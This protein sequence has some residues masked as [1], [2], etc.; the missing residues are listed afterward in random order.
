M[1]IDTE[2]LLSERA[3]G[4]ETVIPTWGPG[5][6]REDLRA[7]RLSR[8]LRA[9]ASGRTAFRSALRRVIHCVRQSPCG[10]LLFFPHS[11]QP[12]GVRTRLALLVLVLASF[13]LTAGVAHAK[14]EVILLRTAG[15]PVLDDAAQRVGGGWRQDLRQAAQS[16][17]TGPTRG[18]VTELLVY[19]DDMTNTSRVHAS[20]HAASGEVP[21]T[22]L[23]AFDPP[24]IML[25]KGMFARPFIRYT[26]PVTFPKLDR[27]TQYFIVFRE[28]AES[29]YDF[30]SLTS[31]TRDDEDAAGAEGWTLANNALGRTIADWNP[32]GGDTIWL[33][34]KG[35]LI[36]LGDADLTALTLQGSDGNV[37]QYNP[38]FD[39]DTRHYSVTVPPEVKNITV[40]PTTSDDDARV[41]YRD[42]R[43][44]PIPDLDPA[45]AGLQT[46]LEVGQNTVR[47]RVVA[48]EGKV[49]VYELTVTRQ[50]L[51]MKD[52][53]L[54]DP[55]DAAILFV[56][57]FTPSQA[58]YKAYVPN[59]T[60]TVTLEPTLNT[61]STKGVSLKFRDPDDVIPD[62]DEATDGHQIPL[63]LG[64]NGI[65]MTATARGQ[66]RDYY[67]T[68][69]RGESADPLTGQLS[70]DKARDDLSGYPAWHFDLLLSEPVRIS[71]TELRQHTFEITNGRIVKAQAAGD[72]P[73]YAA[74][75]RLTLEPITPLE[76]ST[77][78]L[79]SGLECGT[80]GALCVPAADHGGTGDK[81]LGGSP[82]EL[83]LPEWGYSGPTGKGL[84]IRVDDTSQPENRG[85]LGV[86]LLF[87]DSDDKAAASP[88]PVRLRMR[89]VAETGPDKATAGVDYSPADHEIIVPHGMEEYPVNIATLLPDS[90]DDA[91]EKVK[92]RLSDAWSLDPFGMRLYQFKFERRN[93]DADV[94]KT[95]YTV[96]TVITIDAPVEQS[97]TMGTITLSDPTDISPGI[98]EF[99]STRS[100]QNMQKE[101]RVCYD[102]E[103]LDTGTATPGE[104][105]HPQSMRVYMQ[106]DERSRSH[107]VHA[108]R[109][110]VDDEGETVDVQIS[111]ARLCNEPAMG[112]ETLNGTQTWTL[113]EPSAPTGRFRGPPSHDGQT[114]FSMQLML[115]DPVSRTRSEM[116]DQTIKTKGGQ[117]TVDRVDGQ[118][119]RWDISVVPDG[120]E[121]VVLTIGGTGSC[122]DPAT[123]CTEDGEPFPD[124]VTTTVPGPGGPPPLTASFEEVPVTHDG[125]TSFTLR[126]SLSAPVANSVDDLRDHALTVTGGS[127]ETVAAIDGRRDL[128]ELT[129]AP[130]GLGNV[131]VT[132]EAGGDCSDLGTLCTAR[133]AVLS[134]TIRA[135][136]EGP[137]PGP[138]LSV[139]FED[140]PEEHDGNKPFTVNVEFSEP[141]AGI[142]NKLLREI[143]QVDG[144]T[145]VQV[146]R[147]TDNNAHRRV[148]I[149]PDG[150][151]L[152]TLSFPATVDCADPHALCTDAGGKLES[153]VTLA[154][155]G[156]ESATPP[157][158][159][160]ALFSNAPDE[161][162]GTAAF[163]V[164]IEFSEAPVGMNNQTLMEVL[165]VDGGTPLQ[166]QGVNNDPSHYR[167]EIEPDG[168]GTVTVSFA[169]TSNCSDPHALCTDSGGRLESGLSL[170]I[171]GPPP[172]ASGP[173]LTASFVNV[174]QE[175]D[176]EKSFRLEIVFSEV[177]VG[178]TN[179]S[180][181]KIL[182]IN[183]GT[184]GGMTKVDDNA[185]HRRLRIDPIRDRY[186]RIT[187]SLPPTTDCRAEGALCSAAGGK[188][189]QG[190]ETIIPGPVGIRVADAR[191]EEGPDATL[192]FVVSLN[193]SPPY[194]VSVDYAT[195]NGT[196]TAGVDY[197]ATSGTLTFASG[198]TSKTVSVPVHD[199]AHD[200]DDET[201]LFRLSN[202]V[203]GRI[204]DGGVAI[205]TIDNSDHMP[206][207]WLGRLGR[208]AAEQYLEAVESRFRS[209]A[210]PGTTVS[211]AGYG[212]TGAAPGEESALTVHPRPWRDLEDGFDTLEPEA[213]TLTPDELISGSAFSL[214]AGGE[215]PGSL[216]GS[217]WGRG[218]ISMFDGREEDLE[219]DGE[220]TSIMLGGDLAHER[221]TAGAMWA[222]TRGDGQYRE[223]DSGTV[224]S[225]FSGLY[226]YGR[227]ALTD[228]LTAWGIVG[229]GSGTL[230]LAP[231]G[232]D[233][234][235]TDMDLLIGAVG[236]R[237]LLVP[238]PEQGGPELVVTTDVLGVRTRS[239]AVP[240]DLSEAEA[241]ITRSRLGLE[242]TWRGTTVWGGPFTRRLEVGIRHDG[243]DAETGSGIDAGGAVEWSDEPGRLRLAIS[244][245]TLLTHEASGFRDHGFAGAISYDARPGSGLGFTASL[246]QST[247]GA[248]TGGLQ[249]LFEHRTID[250]LGTVSE[251]QGSRV[252]AKAGYGWAAFGGR[253]ISTPWLGLSHSGDSDGYRAGWTLNTRGKGG[254]LVE[255]SLEGAELRQRS[256]ETLDRA[257]R[258]LLL[259]FSARW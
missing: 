121:D 87:R 240:G 119:D 108:K 241:D 200:D 23:A 53:V 52:L 117:V 259:R 229:Y 105:F 59:A 48:P 44:Q 110:S 95:D 34:L 238:A 251:S 143:L 172:V 73:G 184:P 109:D 179:G 176:G 223:T 164:D 65:K 55:D 209:I 67:M 60:D 6:V 170:E 175:H 90:V 61:E 13:T 218:A 97:E 245:R 49:K 19:V 2:A 237:G 12:P 16:F 76:E 10:S 163:T 255:L 258:E 38:A 226:P 195:G 244:G 177:P 47:T 46:S 30:T 220:V 91:G 207:A 5:G 181:R 57:D 203:G 106:P 247:G 62:E 156:P 75:W 225:D 135:M 217:L 129:V 3:G 214:T 173:P 216:T 227:Y 79:K 185:A 256:H 35:H 27:E 158:P 183:G 182:Q 111:N 74:H 134:E 126:L 7:L 145:A 43:A 232:Q 139:S 89:T 99:T 167:V 155:P 152:V 29:K 70:R 151:G 187:V 180:L 92:V 133:G 37:I 219:L 88:R 113:V 17:T 83:T 96:S 18:R 224:T 80:L 39:A 136:V 148:K 14:E 24:I 178:M 252:E 198:E 66:S 28:T 212:L 230:E 250:A 98:A 20:L 157:S 114:R 4:C 153:A 26:T 64:V 51:R 32:S 63:S 94:V 72:S 130:A 201:V 81:L 131:K 165:N 144:G 166:M 197:T 231:E 1:S 199:D 82:E 132:V 150:E 124:T 159:L 204:A 205:G 213:R 102:F 69:I 40:L 56:P 169:A 208:T 54:S 248:A 120:T 154:I 249:R 125:E 149:E 41:R 33:E 100:G 161:H 93:S 192:D 68:V 162:D 236:L 233:A 191:V 235:E 188:L 45:A 36:G 168:E 122:G 15:D 115:S 86:T 253:F 58:Y 186:G 101:K 50:A 127:V 85:R 142:S 31:R 193:R 242:S 118:S 141:P 171:L 77:V 138:P 147:L 137:D 107:W 84:K 146:R 190:I 71:S 22:E 202:P 78:K 221:W 194:T 9:P 206:Q 196:A 211:V 239:A 25:T 228:R 140:P 116:Q 104:D 210:T 243:G 160:I 11:G 123:L 112:L 246:A 254:R 234:I 42:E 8:P 103:T 128:W 222:H 257:D 189:E 174:P 215:A 21:G